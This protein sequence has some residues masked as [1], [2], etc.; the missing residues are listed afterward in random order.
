MKQVPEN[1]KIRLRHMLD[2]A[3][4]AQLF[5]QG[6]TRESLD[7][8]VMLLRAVSMSVGI[9]GEAASRIT[10]EFRDDTPQITWQAIIGTR[11]FIIHAYFQIDKEI[12]WNTLEEHIP[13][14]IVELENLLESEQ[15]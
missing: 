4:E 13:S 6:K 11:N 3:R 14:L 10:Q 12:L 15:G 5:T 9:I 1:D 2:A 7:T 8:D